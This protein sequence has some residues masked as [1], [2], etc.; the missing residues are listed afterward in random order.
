[1]L[2]GLSAWASVALWAGPW[3]I[4]QAYAERSWAWANAIIRGRA[5]HPV[6]Y[7][8]VRWAAFWWVLLILASVTA[9][10]VFLA[11]QPEI[12]RWAARRW[13]QPL[14]TGDVR[15]MSGARQRAVSAGVVLM[16]GALGGA[17]LSGYEA[18]PI[19]PYQMFAG[20]P[21]EARLTIVR[22]Y[23]VDGAG[24]EFP[25]AKPWQLE[26]LDPARAFAAF[27]RLGRKHGWQ[28][29]ELKRATLDVGERYER[30]RVHGDHVGP[31]I[32]RVRVYEDQ[33]AL[34]LERGETLPPDRHELLAEYMLEPANQGR[35]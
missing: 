5:E 2:A 27:R 9:T 1:M 22:V 34:D 33:W 15:A 35:R 30:R 23:G 29:E 16:C 7:Y 10:A 19:T 14:A 13:P 18:W 26:P 12:C 20:S 24:A 28:S 3:L 21:R 32:R 31:A 17:A 11:R 8:L 6:E 4:R 25:L